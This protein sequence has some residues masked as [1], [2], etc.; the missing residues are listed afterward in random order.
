MISG[1][2]VFTRLKVV[3]TGGVPQGYKRT[4]VFT[5]GHRGKQFFWNFPV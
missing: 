4:G 2:K 3:Y 5:L 1:F